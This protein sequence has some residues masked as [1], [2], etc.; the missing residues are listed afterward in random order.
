MSDITI[1]RHA[2]ERMAQRGF[3]MAHIYLALERGQ[4]IYAQETLFIFLG[5]RH[6][7]DMGNLAERLEGLTLVIDPKTRT[8]LTV[9]RNRRFTRKIR[10]QRRP[11]VRVRE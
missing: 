3:K 5:R 6:L 10:F 9:F 8:L 4:K 1:T 2:Q 11:R 7:A